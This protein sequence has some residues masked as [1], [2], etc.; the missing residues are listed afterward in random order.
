MHEL[1]QR[2]LLNP[3]EFLGE[4]CIAPASLCDKFKK[5][6]SQAVQNIIIFGVV[7]GFDVNSKLLLYKAIF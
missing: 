5:A 4:G 6:L 3:V 2:L 1:L 7:A